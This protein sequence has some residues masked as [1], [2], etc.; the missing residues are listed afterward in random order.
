MLFVSIALSA[1][2]YSESVLEMLR[3]IPQLSWIPE[4]PPKFSQHSL[5]QLKSRLLPLSHLF[6]QTTAK[7]TL[8][9][10]TPDSFSWLELKPE[11]MVVLEQGDCGSCWAFSSSGAFSD[12]RCIH[13]LDKT[14]VI[15][16]AQFMVS[17]DT[18]NDGCIG[19][20]MILAQQFIK[21]TG[22]VT[23]KCLSYKS[24]NNVTGKCPQ[25]CDDG[26]AFVLTKSVSFADV[27]ANEESIKAA[28]LQG[29][30]QTG[31]TVY[32]DFLYYKSGVY[33]HQYGLIV[34]GH[35]VAMVGYGEENGV[36]F[37]Q[38]RNSW[39]TDFGENGFFKIARGV[40]ECGI[41]NQC[42]LTQ[43]E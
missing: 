38:V 40:N 43:V 2:F 28:L 13:G 20:N 3:S 1:N 16:S 7:T 21:K 4:I 41:E 27:C 18:M 6:A 26:S 14:K 32:E 34:G 10:E 12:N 42:M 9:A 5:I 23:E 37:W 11:C 22:L 31:F 30:V 39:G 35:G 19:G 36:K 29:A 33:T 24:M 17:C 15:Y 25:T 8:S